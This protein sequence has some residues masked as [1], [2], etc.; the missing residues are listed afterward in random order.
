M[1]YDIHDEDAL[2]RD[3]RQRYLRRFALGA[4]IAVIL[5]L[6]PLSLFLPLLGWLALIAAVALLP[7]ALYIAWYEFRFWLDHKVEREVAQQSRAAGKR[8]RYE[9]DLP[10]AGP[11]LRLTDDGELEA[12]PVRTAYHTHDD[13]D[14]YTESASGSAREESRK[15]RKGR[16]RSAMFD[17]DEFEIPDLLKK[18]KDIVD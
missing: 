15:R 17:T 8:K 11:A 10:P 9:A 1:P 5:A 7:H 16:K 2:R 3:L 14:S 12:V 4:H 6:A 13:E 18:L